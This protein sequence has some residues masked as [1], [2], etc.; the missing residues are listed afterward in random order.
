MKDNWQLSL[1]NKSLKKKETLR[2][3]LNSIG[4]INNKY[5]LEIG[6][7]T[8]VTTYYLRKKGGKWVSADIEQD[9][10]TEA[11]DLNKKNI[12]RIGDRKLGFKSSSFDLVIIINFLEHIRDDRCFITEIN[13]ILKKGGSLIVTVPKNKNTGFI[14]FL[15]RRLKFDSAHGGYGH[16]RD[17]YTCNDLISL[18]KNNG[19]TQPRIDTYS[20]YFTELIEIMLNY[21]YML[22]SKRMKKDHFKG[23]VSPATHNEFNKISNSFKLYSICYPFINLFT[24]LDGLLFFSEGHS[25]ICR[26]EKSS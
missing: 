18:L 5:C 2:I 24:K 9:H 15:K 6:C 11:K 10:V 23:G 7:G 8:G 22:L 21:L 16:Y 20:K 1:F 3:I 17:G 12:I 4:D 19:F 14:P 25:I 13:R 26:T